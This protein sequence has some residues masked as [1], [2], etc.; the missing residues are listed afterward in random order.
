MLGPAG[1]SC[2]QRYLEFF[3]LPNKKAVSAAETA[4][5]NEFSITC[6]FDRLT[7]SMT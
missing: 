6:Q 5:K 2:R 7:N 1:A 4:L 3:E